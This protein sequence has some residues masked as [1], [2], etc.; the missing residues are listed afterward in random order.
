[1]ARD[2]NADGVGFEARIASLEVVL[3]DGKNARNRTV[4]PLGAS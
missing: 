3:F 2:S 4:L 1:V